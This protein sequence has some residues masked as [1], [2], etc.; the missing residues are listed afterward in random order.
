VAMVADPSEWTDAEGGPLEPDPPPGTV[1]DDVAWEI[2]VGPGTEDAEGW[3]YSTSFEHLT[4]K[5]AGGRASQRL[6]D[7]VRRRAWKRIGAT[8]PPADT[9]ETAAAAVQRDAATKKRAVKAFIALVLEMVSRR[10][11]WTLFPWDPSAL[12]FLAAK[13]RDIYKKLQ[14]QAQ[15]RRLFRPGDPVPPSPLHFRVSDAKGANGS[16]QPPLHEERTLLD[17]IRTAAVHSR[18]AYGFAM[19]AGH[20]ESVASFLRMQAFGPLTFDAAGGASAEANL[21]AL[22][23]MAKVRPNDVLFAEWRTGGSKRSV[24]LKSIACVPFFHLSSC[25]CAHQEERK[26]ERDPNSYLLHPP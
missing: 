24:L 10:Q 2:V 7:V 8:A 12:Y 16:Q 18:A 1:G 22:V 25:M 11:I 20:V 13:H 15:D 6:G 26:K 3:Q 23:E 5:R 21:E 14:E 9:G 19:L 4:V 17:D